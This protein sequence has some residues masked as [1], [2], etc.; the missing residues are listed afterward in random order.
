MENRHPEASGGWKAEEQPGGVLLVEAS[1]ADWHPDT[2]PE[3]AESEPSP[4][5]TAC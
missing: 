4:G 1:E 3:G 5:P 2:Q